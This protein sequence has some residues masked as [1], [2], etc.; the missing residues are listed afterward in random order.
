MCNVGFTFYQI[1]LLNEKNELTR[2]LKMTS[3]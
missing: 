1:N 2:Y 3:H